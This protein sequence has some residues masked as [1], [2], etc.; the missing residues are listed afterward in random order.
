MEWVLYETQHTRWYAVKLERPAC[1]RMDASR[2][3][4]S[5]SARNPPRPLNQFADRADAGTSQNTTQA[6][7][8]SSVATSGIVGWRNW[9]VIGEWGD[10]GP[11][12]ES[13]PEVPSPFGIEL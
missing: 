8:S 10:R 5:W 2:T 13:A 3:A 6:T 4:S 7:N 12:P 11:P 9:G 1:T